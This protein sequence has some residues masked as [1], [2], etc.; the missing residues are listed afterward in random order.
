LVIPV[1]NFI[2]KIVDG[3]NSL[4][5]GQKKFTAIAAVIVGVVVP[6]VTML[7]GLFLNLVGTLAKMT[8]GMAL[9]SKGFITGGPIGAFKALS[10][11]S[12]YL[13]LAEMDAAMAAQQL[14]GASQVLNATLI[15]QVGTANAAAAAIANLT[16]AYGA[17]AATQ[18]AAGALPSFGVASAAGTNAA[19]GASVRIRGLRRNAG[20]GVPGVGNTDTVPAMLTPGEFVVNKE[21]TKNNLGL[22]KAIN[23]GGVQGYNKGGKIPGVQ[24]FGT[25]EEVRMVQSLRNIAGGFGQISQTER[26][27]PL[28]TAPLMTSSQFSSLILNSPSLDDMITRLGLSIFGIPDTMNR[29]MASSGGGV[30]V[31]ELLEFLKDGGPDVFE[32]LNDALDQTGSDKRIDTRKMHQQ[33]LQKL[34]EV[35]LSNPDALLKDT[36]SFKKGVSYLGLDELVNQAIDPKDKEILESL[37]QNNQSSGRL[38][39]QRGKKKLESDSRIANVVREYLLANGLIDDQTKIGTR[40]IAGR[41]AKSKPT[42]EIF[43]DKGNIYSRFQYGAT[44]SNTEKGVSYTGLRLSQTFEKILKNLTLKGSKFSGSKL[45]RAHF[46]SGGTVPGSGNSDTVPAMLTPGEFVVNKKAASQNQGILEMMNGGQVKG[47]AFGGLVSAAG[48]VAQMGGMV[49]GNMPLMIAG[50][51]V[52]MLGPLLGK[53]V[54]KGGIDGGPSGISGSVKNLGPIFKNMATVGG[55]LTLGMSSMAAGVALAGFA[56][57]KL[58]KQIN[59]AEKSGAE[60]TNAMYGT[61]KTVEGI[62]KQFG[63]QTFAQGSWKADVKRHWNCKI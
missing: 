41:G 19:K 8:Q 53:A 57:Y 20:G 56:V 44:M 12:K 62:A 5:E 10:Q 49:G 63:N 31:L 25:N 24:Y 27:I 28:K 6:A 29:A 54:G 43:D 18:G 46:A 2:T 52:Q 15:E 35:Q 32:T 39:A 59:N 58:N 51:V 9:F 13:S 11:S 55:R 45:S 50:T 16:K 22:L 23:D 34:Q 42:V 60:F 17:M 21:A 36:P 30:K 48:T 38:N 3:F 37:R 7:A 1:V 40:R 61:S 14:S 33:I 26:F 47:Y 4:S